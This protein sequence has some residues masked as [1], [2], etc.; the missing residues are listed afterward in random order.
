[1]CELGDYWF[2]FRCECCYQIFSDFE[3]LVISVSA[4]II[5]I[6]DGW[7]IRP[8]TDIRCFRRQALFHFDVTVMTVIGAKS[9][10]KIMNQSGSGC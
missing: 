2:L 1:M 10:S 8:D 9:K 6:V 3:R 4:F 5:E 7:G